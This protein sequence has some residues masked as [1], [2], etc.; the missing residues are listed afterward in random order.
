MTATPATRRLRARPRRKRRIALRVLLA[1]L[2]GGVLWV[3]ISDSPVA[4]EVRELIG[5]KPDQTIVDS[6]FSVGAH[7]FRYYKF[8]LPEATVNASV[9]GHFKSTAEGS[10]AT[11]SG[12]RRRNEPSSDDDNSIEAY[13]LTE[14]DFGA[15]RTG[16]TTNSL[17]DSG[18]VSRAPCAPTFRRA[19]EL[20]IWSSATSPTQKRPRQ[21]TPR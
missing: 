4:Q 7:T 18:D 13:I 19:Q 9:A 8:S 5:I 15:W 14:E 3:S 17:Y 11:G 16:N 21:F 12:Q 1:I 20:T 2:V 6:T 10:A